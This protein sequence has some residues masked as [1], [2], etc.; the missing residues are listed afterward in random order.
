MIIDKGDVT[1]FVLGIVT[2]IVA[3]YVWDIYRER[4][5]KLEYSDKKIIEEMTSKI[6]GLRSDIKNGLV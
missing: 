5:K 6:Q 3:N 1:G 2:S 4:K